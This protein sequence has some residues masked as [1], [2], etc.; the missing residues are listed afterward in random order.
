MIH[1]RRTLTALATALSAT[2]ILASCS[3]DDSEPV[4]QGEINNDAPGEVDMSTVE[5]AEGDTVRC[6][7]VSK[8]KG[9]GISC[10]WDNPTTE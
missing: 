5:N 2:M 6:A 3:T 9:A 10:D 4:D 8:S 1:A 7:I